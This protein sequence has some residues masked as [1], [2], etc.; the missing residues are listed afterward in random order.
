MDPP[1]THVTIWH[2]LVVAAVRSKCSMLHSAR[3]QRS[4]SV[5]RAITSTPG[6]LST[7]VTTVRILLTWPRFAGTI[8]TR[9][10]KAGQMPQAVLRKYGSSLTRIVLDL[11]RLLLVGKLLVQTNRQQ[12]DLQWIPPWNPPPLQLL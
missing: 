9:P 6:T 1:Q 12:A 10:L 5:R 8:L 2:Y 11:A 3:E 7:L 4:I